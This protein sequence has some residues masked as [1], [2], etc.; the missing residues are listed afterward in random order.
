[1][2]LTLY[3]LPLRARAEVIRLILAYAKIDYVNVDIPFSEWH[4]HKQSLD[5]CPFGQLPSLKLPSNKVIA[6]SGA[7]TRYVAKIANIYP[8]DPEDAAEADMI[9]EL[10]QEMNA[11]NPILNWFEYNSPQWT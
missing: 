1:M 6:Q 7:I 11:I 3:Y 10:A 4:A 5:I 8:V 9:H 2:S